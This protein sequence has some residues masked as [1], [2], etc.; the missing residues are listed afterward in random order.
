M[1]VWLKYTD[2]FTAVVDK[3]KTLIKTVA[4]GWRGCETREREKRILANEEA[5]GSQAFQ[6][7]ALVSDS[8]RRES[9]ASSGAGTIGWVVHL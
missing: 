4:A 5:Q 1:S 2:C 7:I 9:S 8:A 6:H 3:M